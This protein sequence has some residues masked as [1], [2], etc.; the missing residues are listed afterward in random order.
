MH[1]CTISTSL[2]PIPAGNTEMKTRHI[3]CFIY[4]FLVIIIPG[5]DKSTLHDI[6][7]TVTFLLSFP[8]F[9]FFRNYTASGQAH[10]KTVLHGMFISLTY[11][12]QGYLVYLNALVIFGRFGSAAVTLLKNHPNIF[13]SIATP[14]K[15]I[16]AVTLYLLYIGVFRLFMEINPVIYI[17]LDHELV[18]KGLNIGTLVILVLSPLLEFLWRGTICNPLTAVKLI[19][20]RFGI[21]V[22]ASNFASYASKTNPIGIVVLSLAALCYI[23]A[24]VFEGWRKFGNH[25]R[26]M[27]QL[28]VR[29]RPLPSQDTALEKKSVN[30]SVLLL[31]DNLKKSYPQTTSSVA[32]QHE[33]KT[34]TNLCMPAI[35]A[36]STG[37]AVTTD[38]QSLKVPE[39]HVIEVRPPTKRQGAEAVDASLVEQ[40][41]HTRVD[42]K[43]H[44]TI[45]TP[46][47]TPLSTN[48]SFVNSAFDQNEADAHTEVVATEYEHELG[49]NQMPTRR[50]LSSGL[51]VTSSNLAAEERDP[52][53]AGQLLSP[54]QRKEEKNKLL[55]KAFFA[56]LAVMT[57]MAY[58]FSS[59]SSNN[60]IMSTILVKGYRCLF[61]CMPMYWVLMI[62]DCYNL[63][64]RRIISLLADAFQ[65]YIDS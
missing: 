8:Q 57:I 19:R 35:E 45:E 23:A 3:I 9:Y 42:G 25:Q 13:C 39:I 56:M 36:I 21:N 49:G 15:I 18:V 27:A 62:D 40:L 34:H 17:N 24:L 54:S 6:F 32:I 43:R 51:S 31:P 55:K 52:E 58:L 46:N 4:C 20:N 14:D 22:Q 2:C 12:F 10:T 30:K 5:S 50:V 63:A 60:G 47:N 16:L 38:V 1:I 7:Q 41:E 33:A 53:Q 59:P 37:N 61:I 64:K 11:A 26:A 65:I 29:T 28:A 44:N 48:S